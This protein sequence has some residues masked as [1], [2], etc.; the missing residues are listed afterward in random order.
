[1][2]SIAI[3]PNLIMLFVS[4]DFEIIDEVLSAIYLKYPDA[5]V[6]GCSTAGEISNVTVTDK[7]ISLTA[8]QFDKTS[9]KLVSVKLDSEVDSSKAG[10]RIGNMLYN[11]DLK[12]V[13][14]LSDGL[15]INGADL[16]SGLK[17]ALPNISVTGGLAADGEDFE[18]T[19]VIKN[20]Q[21]LEKTVLGLGFMA[22]I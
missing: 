4:P 9:L 12:H 17:S 15:N 3:E 6:F 11:D 19:F 2:A 1:M 20:N 14:V 13:M 5:L 18:K 16:V 8:I 10:E 22:I 21:V 7:S